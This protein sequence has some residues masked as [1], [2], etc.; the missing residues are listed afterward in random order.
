[1]KS[2]WYIKH[3][4][5]YHDIVNEQYRMNVKGIEIG[6]FPVARH[7]YCRYFGLFYENKKPNYFW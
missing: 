7:G 4:D 3:F 5:D 2:F 6:C 1:M